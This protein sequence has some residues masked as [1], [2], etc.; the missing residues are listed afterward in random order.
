[1]SSYSSSCF[2][3][4][5]K[6]KYN[7]RLLKATRKSFGDATDSEKSEIAALF[8]L[9]SVLVIQPAFRRSLLIEELTIE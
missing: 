7:N 3:H 9:R 2:V 4:L 1:M 8:R 6:R 5:L